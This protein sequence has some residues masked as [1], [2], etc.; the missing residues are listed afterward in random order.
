MTLI[1]AK[2]PFIKGELW[3]SHTQSRWSMSSL[4]RPSAL[5]LSL[6]LERTVPLSPLSKTQTHIWWCS[7]WMLFQT[8]RFCLFACLFVF[9]SN[10]N[11]LAFKLK[12][13]V[14]ETKSYPQMLQNSTYALCLQTSPSVWPHLFLQPLLYLMSWVVRHVSVVKGTCLQLL[15]IACYSLPCVFA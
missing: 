6:L 10:I 4:C 2:P 9:S 3:H 14:L 1:T 13:I 15:K 8:H 11:L 7:V 12:Y 5:Q